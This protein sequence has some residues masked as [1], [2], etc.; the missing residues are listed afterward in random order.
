M[1]NTNL[2]RVLLNQ[3]YIPTPK[4]SHSS[5]VMPTCRLDA[6][7]TFLSKWSPKFQSFPNHVHLVFD[8]MA[9]GISD[10]QL[11]AIRK[12]DKN[13]HI[14]SWDRTFIREVM[15]GPM[16]SNLPP[17][18][19]DLESQNI[20]CFSRKDSAI[21][22]YGFLVASSYAVNSESPPASPDDHVIY[23]LDDDCMPILDENGDCDFFSAHAGNLLRFRPWGSTVPGIRVRGIPY[24]TH[25]KYY[26]DSDGI[27]LSV[28]CWTGIPD[29]DSVQRLSLGDIS[30]SVKLPLAS[31]AILA[32]PEILYPICGMNMAMKQSMLPA[33]LFAPM[34]T[35]S[36]YKR[37]DDIWF[38]IIAQMSLR[39]ADRSW[40]YGSPL[41]NHVRLSLPMDCLVAE[42]PGIRLNEQLWVFISEAIAA[43]LETNEELCSKAL[44]ALPRT[45]S[46]EV[47]DEASSNMDLMI[48][49]V[50]YV[51][52]AMLY[53]K[54]M[55]FSPDN[56]LQEKYS[57]ECID[58]VELWCECLS[59]WIRLIKRYVLLDNSIS[60]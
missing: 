22:S 54:G 26:F 19:L 55:A 6:A 7:I 23:T 28:G 47:G 43:Y 35:A 59:N 36:N 45:I 27:L 41:I 57:Q 52:K 18:L 24:Y 34:G 29:F 33:A 39:C 58:Y 37:F 10:D 44:S 20:K 30:D 48:G 46:V 53:F 9:A 21:R 2:D 60:I 13:I 38:G 4:F 51:I 17:T 14:H 31:E 40:C 11:D 15:P 5:L 56:N 50:D 12:I 8:G 25:S 16:F 3:K 42:A 1:M 49:S 32:H